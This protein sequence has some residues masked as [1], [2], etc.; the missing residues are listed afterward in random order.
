[1]RIDYAPR[2]LKDVKR[3]TKK[4]YQIDKLRSVIELINK[5]DTESN[6]ILVQRDKL[7]AL[8][9]DWTGYLECHVDNSGDWI[10]V[11]KIEGDILVL[12]R[13]GKHDDVFRS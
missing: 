6:R 5:N 4:N 3:L 2:F 1:M 7:H 13:T 9:G 10:L 8:K 11:Y 12:T